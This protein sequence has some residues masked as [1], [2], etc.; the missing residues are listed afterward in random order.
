MAFSPDARRLFVSRA[1]GQSV[2]LN[3]ETGKT[4]PPLESAAQSR[5]RAEAHAFTGDGRLLAMRGTS[6]GDVNMMVPDG[7]KGRVV[8][9]RREVATFLAVWD[10]ESG[11]V[12]KRWD[13]SPRVLFHPSK[14]VLAILEPNGENQTRLGLWDF[15]A[16]VEKK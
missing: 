1:I 8:A 14:P 3:A 16:E 13:S 11:K 7:Q 15:S 4:M 2:V 12:V 9:V 6:Y 5:L 10:T